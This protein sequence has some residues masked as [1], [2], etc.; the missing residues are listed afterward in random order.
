MRTVSWSKATQ[1]SEGITWSSGFL[2]LSLLP[3][4]SLPHSPSIF[5]DNRDAV[6]LD[7]HPPPP[8]IPLLLRTTFLCLR[9]DLSG[10]RCDAFSL[11]PPPLR[12]LLNCFPSE[13]PLIH[14]LLLHS[15]LSCS[16]KN[17]EESKRKTLVSTSASLQ[18]L[19]C[20]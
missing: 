3:L 16:R 12:E 7:T 4:S 20:F 6:G 2:L 14:S 11:S 19:Y 17:Q 9:H 5:G 10:H 15:P 1:D 8:V 18:H 13:F